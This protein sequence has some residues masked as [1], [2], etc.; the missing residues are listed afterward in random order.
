MSDAFDPE[1]GEI[2]SEF[3][4][5]PTIE[6]ETSRSIAA[7]AAALAKAQGDIG[8]AHR[9]SKNPHFNSK[10]AS[11]DAVQD[12]CREPLSKAGIAT[13]QV[14]FNDGDNVGV[15][16]MLVHSS[17]E[18]IKG[19]LAV[20]P[21]KYDAQGVGSVITYLRRYLLGAM[22][23]VAPAD[24]DGNAAVGRPDQ[25]QRPQP[26]P[27][28]VT[29]APSQDTGRGR[30]QEPPGG[31]RAQPQEAAKAAEDPMRSKYKELRDLVNGASDDVILTE[32]ENRYGAF[33]E[34]LKKKQPAAFDQMMR[35]FSSRRA[36]FAPAETADEGDGFV[37]ELGE[38]VPV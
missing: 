6:F 5:A 23:G 2:V 18:W 30:S 34:E 25:A 19:K 37:D 8:S 4:P 27:A 15:V 29:Q 36:A 38:E 3:Q 17:G 28:A 9:D 24:D 35:F 10:Y 26:R 14:P 20:K 11:L 33:I 21:V 32:L 22:V 7:L 31:T 1:T 12:A 16:T 13:M